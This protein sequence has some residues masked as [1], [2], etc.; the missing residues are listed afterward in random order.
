M[1]LR[2]INREGE[3]IEVKINKN[4]IIDVKKLTDE[5]TLEDEYYIIPAF[6]DIHTH[7]GYGTDF[8]DN[9][10]ES[11]RLYLRKLPQEGTSSIVHTTITTP[12]ENLDSSLKIAKFVQDN[13]MNNESRLL[14]VN[15]E[16]NYL[17]PIKKGA[18]KE[19]LLEPLTKQEVDFLSKYNNVKIISH[20]IE[21]ST[22]DTTEY[23]VS[24]GIIPSAAH[25]IATGEETLEHMDKGLKGITHTYNA[26]PS[27]ENRSDNVLNRSLTEDNLY[28]EIIVDGIHVSPAM[29]KLLYKIKPLNKILIITDSSPA[30]GMPDGEY[31]LGE[32]KTVKEGNILRTKNDGALAASIATMHM[33]FTN[34]IKFTNCSIAEA[35]IMTSTNQAEYLGINNIGKIEK[36][37]L[38]DILV[39]D[40][41]LNIVKTIV[42]GN[43][44]YE[45]KV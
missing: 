40:K 15:I 21:L 32:I 44:L 7:G 23:M 22:V 6:I 8:A 14:G 38:A 25:T 10:E 27:M 20:A 9:S 45:A 37:Y 4:K 30:K 34:F 36:N 39:L 18:H 42:N 19:E 41:N 12:K 24:K 26:M 16:G 5:K 13:P 11:T 29:I 1:N 2:G 17:N 28:T 3:L 35:S 43:V 31:M 33:C